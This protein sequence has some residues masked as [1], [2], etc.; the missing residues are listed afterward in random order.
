MNFNIGSKYTELFNESNAN[1]ESGEFNYLTI[2][3]ELDITG[4]TIVGFPVDDITVEFVNNILQVKDGGISDVKISNLNASK[5]FGT[6]TIPVDNASVK[7]GGLIT[8]SISDNGS[9]LAIKSSFDI[10]YNTLNHRFVDDINVIFEL[11]LLEAKLFTI[12][13]M[14]NNDIKNADNITC[15][16]INTDMIDEKTLNSGVTIEGVLIKD[17]Q[18]DSGQG[19]TDLY[20]MDQNVRMIDDVTFNHLK[21]TG[22]IVDVGNITMTGALNTPGTI[23]CS[24]I[25]TGFG[26]VECYAM[27]Q[28]VR[29]I[30]NVM[31]NRVTVNDPVIIGT[32]APRGTIDTL[33]EVLRCPGPTSDMILAPQDGT[34]RIHMY[35]NSS[36][37]P[38]N[39]LVSGEPSG[40]WEFSPNASDRLLSV[41]YAPNGTQGN[42]I[43]WQRK[44]A[45]DGPSGNISIGSTSTGYVLPPTRGTDEQILVTN[46]TGIVTWKN[47]KIH[48]SVLPNLVSTTNLPAT[49]AYFSWQHSEYNL[50]SSPG[51]C[52][53]WGSNL[54]DRNLIVDITST[55]GPH[56]TTTV[57]SGSPDGIY[58]FTFT[59]PTSD[60]YLSITISKS[61]F[62]GNNPEVRG[63]Q[64]VF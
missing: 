6:L 33:D 49:I 13:N 59:L 46:S 10:I 7:T 5:L 2:N 55:L 19:L 45:V 61:A 38:N 52:L 50:F 11:S 35:W 40:K 32:D 3:N 58:S 9:D 25:D 48:F 34:G 36:T 26:Q 22:N 4:T 15:N 63:I 31:F 42:P 43:T 1:F 27:N 56:G 29:T 18:I 62:G 54:V 60:T 41:E 39:Y 57:V 12:L 8:N 37:T 21:L 14:D 51:K 64:F 17:G 28:P 16:S 44:F 24:S 23:T 47:P 30:D 53:F 20:L